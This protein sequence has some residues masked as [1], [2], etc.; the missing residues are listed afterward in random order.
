[1]SSI[2]CKS[3]RNTPRCN[4]WIDCYPLLPS[5]CLPFFSR[6]QLAYSDSCK[7]KLLILE[8]RFLHEMCII[9]KQWFFYMKYTLFL[10]ND[11]LILF[12]QYE[13]TLECALLTL[14]DNELCVQFLFMIKI[15]FGVYHL[16]W[17]FS[18]L[19]FVKMICQLWFSS[20]NT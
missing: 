6:H 18:V 4:R 8:I 15:H 16:Y 9:S 19:L 12:W 11:K 2:I 7:G 17:K 3:Y 14:V 13:H 20:V 1:M 10:N 5:L